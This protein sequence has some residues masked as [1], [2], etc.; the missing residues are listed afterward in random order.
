[1]AK[2]CPAEA[3]HAFRVDATARR[4]TTGGSAKTAPTQRP[5]SYKAR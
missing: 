2:A 1:M 4:L 3:G 5:V